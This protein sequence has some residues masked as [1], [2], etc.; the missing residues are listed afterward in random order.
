MVEDNEYTDKQT[1]GR[2]I[3]EEN[4]FTLLLKLRNTFSKFAYKSTCINAQ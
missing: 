4:S 3:N 2:N 1:D